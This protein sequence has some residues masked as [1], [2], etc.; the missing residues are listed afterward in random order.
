MKV[1]LTCVYLYMLP[2]LVRI[3]ICDLIILFI[4]FQDTELVQQLKE[5]GPSA[6]DLEVQSLAPEGGG[7]INLMLAFMDFLSHSFSTNRDYELLQA[8]LALFLK[9]GHFLKCCSG[10]FSCGIRK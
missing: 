3:I 4:T 2:F 6:I 10:I 5:M 1:K 7:S 8:Y 9:V